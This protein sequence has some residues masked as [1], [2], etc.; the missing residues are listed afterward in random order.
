MTK[1]TFFGFLKRQ[2]IAFATVFILFSLIFPA[3][4]LIP[5]QK[6]SADH[7]TGHRDLT[8][9][10]FLKEP[11][12]LQSQRDPRWADKKIG[13]NQDVKMATC[14]CFLAAL[15]TVGNFMLDGA[16][17]GQGHSRLWP[18]VLPPD[19][20]WASTELTPAYIDEFL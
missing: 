19:S 15:S 1:A 2:L 3:L 12:V 11:L 8:R 4:D 9:D 17:D 18:G 14:G 16:L 13:P 5:V 10:S 7:V 6:A 20:P